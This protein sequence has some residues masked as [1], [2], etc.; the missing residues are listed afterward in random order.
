MNTTIKIDGL[1][2]EGIIL[3]NY[4]QTSKYIG[5]DAFGHPQFNTTYTEVGQLLHSMK[6]N[7]HFDTSKDIVDF[8]IDF[9][10]LWLNDKV[11]DIILP[12]PPT[13]ERFLQPVYAIGEEISKRLNIPYSDKV[14]RKTNNKSAKNMPKD[15]KQLKGSIIQLKSA[16]RKCNILL[17]DDFYSTGE[18]ANEC[19]LTLK[20]DRLIDKIYYLAIAKTK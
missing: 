17:I 13:N 9:L 15:N 16:K 19:V 4:V 3:D 7:G 5:E 20:K 18:T 2:D 6:Y 12:I 1:W 8:C 10:S 11:I 14:L